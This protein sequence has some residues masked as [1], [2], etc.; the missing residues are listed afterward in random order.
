MLTVFID[1]QPI[2]T[3]DHDRT[4]SLMQSSFII[5]SANAVSGTVLLWVASQFFFAQFELLASSYAAH[6]L[7]MILVRPRDFRTQSELGKSSI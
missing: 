1:F 3:S 5:D 2:P 6:S 4:I 7:A